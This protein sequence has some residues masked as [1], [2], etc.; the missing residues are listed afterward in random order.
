M[1]ASSVRHL[2]P[3]DKTFKIEVFTWRCTFICFHLKFL[4]NLVLGFRKE[5]SFHCLA[6]RCERIKKV[7]I[8]EAMP[9]QIYTFSDCYAEQ[10]IRLYNLLFIVIFYTFCCY[11]NLVDETDQIFFGFYYYQ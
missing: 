11:N 4:I 10:R 1:H 6:L 9:L 8:L 3:E 5:L 7:L 2:K